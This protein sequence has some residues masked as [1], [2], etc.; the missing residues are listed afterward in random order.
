MAA[1]VIQMEETNRCDL[2]GYRSE[3]GFLDRARHLKNEHPAYAKGLLFRVAAPGIFLIEVVVMA[4][5]HAPEWA[6]IVA[7]FSSFGLLFFGKQRSRAERRA[8]GTRPTMPLTRLVREG[9]LGFMLIVPV[10]ALL[11]VVMSRR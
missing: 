3:G 2:C 5:I 8:A 4:A 7:L 10:I 6:F 1:K 9:G 11:I